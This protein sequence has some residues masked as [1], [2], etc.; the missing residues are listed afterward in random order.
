MSSGDLAEGLL[1]ADYDPKRAVLEKIDDGAARYLE[2]MGES[3][4]VC[5]VHPTQ[6]V[7]HP[8][9]RVEASS[10]ILP[11]EF[12]LGRPSRQERQPHEQN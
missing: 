7:E 5:Y 9:I 10:R 12:W 11:N 1:W 2:R 8:S 4:T 3:P 6:Q